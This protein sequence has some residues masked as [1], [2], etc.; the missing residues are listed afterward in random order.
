MTLSGQDISQYQG[1]I[2]FSIYKNN[3]NFVICKATEGV[4]FIDQWFGNNRQKA[5]DNNLLRGWYHFAR[6]DL[7]PDPIPEADY[8]LSVCWDIQPGEL[9]FLDYETQF[10]GDN[11]KWVKGFMDRIAER[12]KG[13]RP[14]FY[15]YQS[16]LKSFDW[17]PLINDNV[18]LWLAA[19]TNDPSNQN[20]DTGQFPFAAFWQW[21][22]EAVPGIQGQVDADLFFGDK[23]AF[24][25]Y[26]YYEPIVKNVVNN[27]DNVVNN[28]VNTTPDNTITQPVIGVSTPTVQASTTGINP[29][30]PIIQVNPPQPTTVTI[31]SPKEPEKINI[32]FWTKFLNSFEEFLRNWF[33]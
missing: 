30:S 15:T 13:Y 11:V 26:G 28:V 33:K 27:I 12:L 10:N 17:S 8:F 32:S 29:E 1:N 3:T 25:A 20:F 6:P 18:G 21:G 19:P 2:D 9:L 23:T 5:R 31:T 22:N 16:M 24:L 7:N 14:L 4:G